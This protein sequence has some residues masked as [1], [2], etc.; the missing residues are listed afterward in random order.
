MGNRFEVWSW[1]FIE[2]LEESPNRG[3]YRYIQKYAGESFD[4]AMSVMCALKSGGAPCV[5]LEWR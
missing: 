3:D 4:E 1:E 5:K 2:T